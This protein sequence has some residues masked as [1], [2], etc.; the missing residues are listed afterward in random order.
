MDIRDIFSN[1]HA[2]S[3]EGVMLHHSLSMY[4]EFI[5]LSSKIG[6]HGYLAM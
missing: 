1:I 4:F 6:D 2:H 3:I 5:G